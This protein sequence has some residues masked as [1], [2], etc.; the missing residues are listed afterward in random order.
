MNYLLIAIAAAILWFVFTSFNTR[1]NFTNQVE[2]FEVSGPLDAQLPQIVDGLRNLKT[3]ADS[4][5][6]TN[7]FTFPGQMNIMTDLVVGDT[8]R[9]WGSNIK[10]R[11]GQKEG[12]YV[13]FLDNKNQRQAY[14]QGS[15]GAVNVV[16]QL[17]VSGGMRTGLNVTAGQDLVVTRHA[18]LGGEIYIDGPNKW[19]IHTPDDARREL[20][21]A[22]RNDNGSPLWGNALILYQNGDVKVS[23]A[24]RGGRL[25][26]R[27]LCIRTDG[28]HEQEWNNTD[29]FLCAV[30]NEGAWTM[31]F[32]I[33]EYEVRADGVDQV[34]TKP[35]YRAS[36]MIGN[37]WR[38]VTSN[39]RAGLPNP[40]TAFTR[41]RV[42]R[43]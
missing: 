20:H 28:H 24:L 23:G 41:I 30:I 14:I 17:G 11:S 43:I 34:N 19:V 9:E 22:P 38:V 13:D 8:S 3:I 10:I 18:Y 27:R 35:G 42:E 40:N 2:K 29:D 15:P 32:G 39:G 25:N 4:L 6:T 16:G 31:Y 1:E 21:I 36:I 5:V 12:G 26:E 33:G 37:A 7:Q